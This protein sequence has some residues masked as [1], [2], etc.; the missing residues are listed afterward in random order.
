MLSR[1][2]DICSQL[3]YT[4]AARPHG[5]LSTAKA[6]DALANR[7]SPLAHSTVRTQAASGIGRV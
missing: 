3:A 6:V 2:G 7:K 5:S 4:A 1:I